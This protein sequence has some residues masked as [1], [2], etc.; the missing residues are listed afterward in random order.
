M[1]VQGVHM[2]A[3]DKEQM[4]RRANC[5]HEHAWCNKGLGMKVKA[6]MSAVCQKATLVW[7]RAWLQELDA[8]RLRAAG[9]KADGASEDGHAFQ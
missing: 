7:H 1:Q 4:G 9:G 2:R 8:R 6:G 3:M 5:T